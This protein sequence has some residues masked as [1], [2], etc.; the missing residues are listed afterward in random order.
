MRLGSKSFCLYPL[1]L[2]SIQ[3]WLEK[4]GSSA[5]AFIMS[6]GGFGV[7][8]L[9]MGDSSFLTIPEANDVLIV[10]LSVGGSWGHM[11]YFVGMTIIGS[12]IGCMLLYFL[13]RKG[14][15]PI[16]RRKFSQ[17][18]L[19]RAERLF[20]RYGIL[21]IIIPSI[22]PPPTPFKIFVLC[23]GVFRLNPWI[24]LMAVVIGRTIRYSLWGILAVL[25]GE[26]VKAYMQQN[27]NA[28]GMILFIGFVLTLAIVFGFYL[29]Q[30]KEK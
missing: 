7:L 24:F 5:Q 23:A 15:N 8:L 4:M 26:S 17:Q 11:T 25:Y 6:F 20:K 10:L 14:G 28:V 18:R 16:L 19:E 3:Q 27:I 29:H 9:A 12:V 2:L 30:A 13:G 22:L 21:T 1:L